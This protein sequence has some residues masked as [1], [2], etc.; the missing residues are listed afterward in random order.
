MLPGPFRPIRRDQLIHRR[1]D[2]PPYRLACHV[3]GR[4]HG[5]GRHGRFDRC[6]SA[7]PLDK[8]MARAMA[9]TRSHR[10][11]NICIYVGG[12]NAKYPTN[13]DIIKGIHKRGINRKSEAFRRY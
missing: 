9:S 2:A 10:T 1:Q 4:G 8:Y 6:V 3:A 13:L 12:W 11:S 5:I 7:Q